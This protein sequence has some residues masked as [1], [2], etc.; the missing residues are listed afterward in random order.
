MAS[1]WFGGR[2]EASRR[3]AGLLIGDFAMIGLFVLL[4]EL[5]HSG[6]LASGI[7]TFMQFGIGW[8]LVS[9]LARVYDS[10]A[11]A[12]PRQAVVQIVITWVLAA[13]IGQLVRL[14]M[15]PGNLILPSFVAVSIG[16]G[17][18]FLGIWRYGAARI[19][20]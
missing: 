19:M 2:L 4:G 20:A 13:L 10:R 5:R 15:T 11:L 6:T 17:G 9:L 1:D 12:S 14:V 18:L 16:F 3:T 7:E 8:L